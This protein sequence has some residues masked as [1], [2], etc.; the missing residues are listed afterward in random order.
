ME[1]KCRPD[2]DPEG[3]GGFKQRIKLPFDFQPGTTESVGYNWLQSPS[4]NKGFVR[5]FKGGSRKTKSLAL[6]MGMQHQR[7][8]KSCVCEQS[9]NK[10]AGRIMTYPGRVIGQAPDMDTVHQVVVAGR[11][12][13]T[14]DAG[15]SRPCL[16]RPSVPAALDWQVTQVSCCGTEP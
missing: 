11:S 7:K 9:A 10:S 14:P 5:Q 1:Y 8:I 13:V 2:L 15:S 4:Q 6:E 16:S 3:L 12:G